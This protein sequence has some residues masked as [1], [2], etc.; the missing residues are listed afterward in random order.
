MAPKLC[1]FQGSQG[2]FIKRKHYIKYTY[3]TS[4]YQYPYVALGCLF[5]KNTT[6]LDIT[7]TLTCGGTGYDSADN[8]RVWVGIPNA[9][10]ET[11]TWT[12]AYSYSSSTS[13]TTGTP[14]ITVP[15]NSTVVVM[16]CS[17]SYYI[18][19]PT[20][21]SSVSYK[22][23]AQF[24]YWR[25]NKVRTDFLKEGL[26]IDFDKTLKAWQCP[27]FSSPFELLM[28]TASI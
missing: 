18:A 13:W 6:E 27:G 8:L 1:F 7:S 21:S 26:E 5:V 16:F 12:T 28:P 14:S 9:A 2:N 3:T 23:H 17:A 25:L 22:Y 19:A 15:A 20:D 24:L 4:Q 10:T 11:I